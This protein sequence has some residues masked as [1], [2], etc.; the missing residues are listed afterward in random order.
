MA[1]RGVSS[2]SA[3]RFASWTAVALGV[4]LTVAGV[5]AAPASARPH[6]A[7][8]TANLQKMLNPAGAA[9]V[10]PAEEESARQAFAASHF[11][12]AGLSDPMALQQSLSRSIAQAAVVPQSTRAAKGWK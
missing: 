10:N 1:R 6:A 4:S 2:M 9:T 5:V 7:A 11:G 3:H 8:S 12:G